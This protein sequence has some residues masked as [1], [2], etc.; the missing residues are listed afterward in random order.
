MNKLMKLLINLP[1]CKLAEIDPQLPILVSDQFKADEINIRY[2]VSEKP[3][4]MDGTAQ[5]T[6]REFIAAG[7]NHSQLVEVGYAHWYVKPEPCSPAPSAIAPA[8]TVRAIVF[9]AQLSKGKEQLLK[10]WSVEQLFNFKLIDRLGMLR[11]YDELI[12]SGWTDDQ[13]VRVGYGEWK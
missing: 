4:V 1:I 11:G 2:N 8:P 5:S 9:P 7:W 10:I 12:Q 13:L 3:I 6:Y